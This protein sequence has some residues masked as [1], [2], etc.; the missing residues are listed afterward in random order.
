MWCMAEQHSSSW[1]YRRAEI[2]GRQSSLTADRE[3]KR[4]ESRREERWE[5]YREHVVKWNEVPFVADK[6]ILLP[7]P[8]S[9]KQFE[10]NECSLFYRWQTTKPFTDMQRDI[11]PSNKRLRFLFVHSWLCFLN[12]VR[13]CL[14]CHQADRIR[15]WWWD[16]GIVGIQVQTLENVAE[17]EAKWRVY[18][19][20]GQTVAQF[21]AR[22]VG[23]WSWGLLWNRDA[24]T[25]K[26]IQYIITFHPR[27]IIGSKRSG[28]I[29]HELV[30]FLFYHVGLWEHRVGLR[31]HRHAHICVRLDLFE[32]LC[33]V[34][35]WCSILLT[36]RSYLPTYPSKLQQHYY[37][38][39]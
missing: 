1:V 28:W 15:S 39:H 18:G 8:A 20:C 17:E 23:P 31:E 38:I 35:L 27:A 33:C 13:S 29:L 9:L 11:G 26:H 32:G 12:R 24:H 34:K 30:F 10:H 5:Q 3:W 36:S 21:P 16:Q 4:S 14:F 7:W 6:I 19:I 2:V 37:F 25:Q 22:F